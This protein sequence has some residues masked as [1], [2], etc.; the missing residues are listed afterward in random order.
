MSPEV[1]KLVK[2]I[3]S[4]SSTVDVQLNAETLIGTD[5]FAAGCVIAYLYSNGKHPFEHGLQN[6]TQNILTG[7]RRR[8]KNMGII[9][10]QHI[11]LI[12][13]LTAH[14]AETRWNPQMCLDRSTLFASE[15]RDQAATILMDSI[16]FRKRP[17]GSCRD[18]LEKMQLF[19]ND[20]ETQMNKM[21]EQVDGQVTKLMAQTSSLPVRLDEDSLFAIVAYTLDTGK[22]RTTNVYYVLNQVLRARKTDK[23]SFRAWQGFLFFL[24]RGLDLL[25]AE[26]RAI[27]YRGGNQGLDQKTVARDYTIGRP[28]Q[29]AAFSSTTIS[30]SGVRLFVR[31]NEGV[32]FKITTLTGRNIGPYSFFPKES[33]VLLSPNARFTVTRSLYKDE[34][35]YSCVDL[36]E[37]QGGVLNS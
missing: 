12:E 36:M 2:A 9:N 8:L 15:S 4:G 24:M 26:E 34:A 6:I 7:Q 18:Q 19:K 5:S 27:V 3:K 32:I 1:L 16:T 30:S 31:K 35:G 25:K 11:S 28:I 33:E 13:H 17:Q 14:K 37:T 23:I 29:W 22:D 10:K 21:L 20:A